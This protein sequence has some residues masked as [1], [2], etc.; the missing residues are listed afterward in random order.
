MLLEDVLCHPWLSGVE[1]QRLEN[2]QTDGLVSI[3]GLPVLVPDRLLLAD[4][5]LWPA[6]D[7][8]G[9][10][11]SVHCVHSTPQFVLQSL[12]VRHSHEAV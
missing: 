3:H 9:A 4:R 11:Q 5:C 10:G 1:Q 12:L 7:L 8:A 6:P 2:R